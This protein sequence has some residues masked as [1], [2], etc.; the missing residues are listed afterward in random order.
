VRIAECRPSA[1]IVR[2]VID[3]P[4]SALRTLDSAF[5]TGASRSLKPDTWQC[6]STWPAP[7]LSRRTRTADEGLSGTPQRTPTSAGRVQS[8]DPTAAPQL[9]RRRLAAVW[10]VIK[11]PS[12]INASNKP[13]DRSA[14]VN[15]SKRV[16]SRT[17]R[18]SPLNTPNRSRTSA[19]EQ[20]NTPAGRTP[21]GFNAGIGIATLSL[22]PPVTMARTMC[23][24]NS[25]F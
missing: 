10:A 5:E 17:R 20:S 19:R 4:H 12:T 15:S 25:G 24:C 6:A 3:T 2:S 21:S 9:N 14:R 22:S 23:P 1:K 8:Y 11:L 16:K 7:Q 13:L 18:S